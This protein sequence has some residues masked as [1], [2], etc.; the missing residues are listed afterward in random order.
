MGEQTLLPHHFGVATPT[1]H[2]H[3]HCSD[4]RHQLIELIQ[5][6]VSV[7]QRCTTT[8]H[9]LQTTPLRENQQRY[10]SNHGGP[11]PLKA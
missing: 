2:F 5:E 9:V 4:L 8:M 10:L 7:S 1:R 3:L 11:T 6:L